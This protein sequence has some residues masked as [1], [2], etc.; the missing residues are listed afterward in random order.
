MD[1]IWIREPNT[2]DAYRT[3]Y[4][5]IKADNYLG[6]ESVFPFQGP[7]RVGD[8]MVFQVA[9]RMLVTTTWKGSYHDD[10]QQYDTI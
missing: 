9:L 1:M 4:K 2:V 3:S 5:A 7:W 6:L 8:D 10:R